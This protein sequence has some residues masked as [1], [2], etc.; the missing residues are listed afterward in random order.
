MQQQLRV[1]SPSS[2]QV[3]LNV[4]VG[5]AASFTVP[6]VGQKIKLKVPET[7]E[8]LRASK[9]AHGRQTKGQWLTDS[10]RKDAMRWQASGHLLSPLLKRLEKLNNGYGKNKKAVFVCVIKAPFTLSG[11]VGKTFFPVKL[12]D[13]LEFSLCNNWFEG[14][15]GVNP[16]TPSV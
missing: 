15:D 3:S 9:D 8:M 14:F 4:M 16:D 11:V 1:V 5:G 12:E 13:G 10:E 6:V 7:L 2:Q